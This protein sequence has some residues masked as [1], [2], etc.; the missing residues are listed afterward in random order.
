MPRSVNFENAGQLFNIDL[1]P[2]GRLTFNANDVD[3]GGFRRLQIDDDSGQL[4]IGGGGEF[5]AIQLLSNVNTNLIFI[6][7]T[8]T[9][10]TAL[11]GGGNSGQNGF[12]RLGNA[13]G[14]TT[15]DMDGSGG[16][17]I[18]GANPAG[19]TPGQD[20]DLALRDS[21]GGTRIRLSGVD[22]KITCT[23]LTQTS[24]VRL[25]QNIAPISNALDKVTALRGVYYEWKR[26]D[27]SELG[28][29]EGSQVGLIGQEVEAVCPELVATDTEGYKSLNY[30]RL[31]A[32]LVEAVKEQQQLIQMQASALAEAIRRIAQ[33]ERALDAQ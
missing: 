27:R 23:T 30:S 5:G 19:G 14:L 20:G 22:G 12:V 10:A 11:L 33:V 29:D 25:K 21:N 32:V 15:V 7:S 6:G 31:T 9:E 17:V 3:G 4:T 1:D 16:N 18:L 28:R 8:A 24:D 26:E 13:A 2:Q